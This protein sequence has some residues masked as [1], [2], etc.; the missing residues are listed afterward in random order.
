[1]TCILCDSKSCV[2]YA[3]IAGINYQQ[4]QTCDLIF[5]NPQNR[6]SAQAEKARYEKHENNVLDDGYQKFVAPLIA[7][8][9]QKIWSE[10]SLG[11][12]FGSGPGDSAVS[13]LLQKQNYTLKKYDPFFHNDLSVLQHNTYDYIV[14]C[15]VVEHFYSPKDEFEKLKSYLKPGGYLFLMTSL[16]T[17]TIDF[18]TWSYRRDQTHVCFYSEKSFQYIKNQFRFKTLS[19]QPNQ[20]VITLQ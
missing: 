19:I 17:E 13:Y 5:M 1:M 15:E 14:S 7:E 2:S 12:D 6:I 4:C 16:K 20:Q 8:I 10:N 11:L 9:T 18:K 3:D